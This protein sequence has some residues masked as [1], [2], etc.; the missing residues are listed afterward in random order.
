[1]LKRKA[2]R[3]GLVLIIAAHP[4]K[5]SEDKKPTLWSISGSAHW[6]NK[7]DHGLIIHRPSRKSNSVLL[8]IEKTKDH[9]TMGIPGEK[10]LLFDRDRCDYD[11]VPEAAS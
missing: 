1:M 10:W 9:E 2:R 4:V 7:S 11:E 5:L 8:T 6:R 3:Y